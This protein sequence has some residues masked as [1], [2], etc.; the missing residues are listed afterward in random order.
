MDRPREPLP[1]RVQDTQILPAAYDDALD[2]GLAELGLALPDAARAATTACTCTG[3][4]D[5]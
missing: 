1:T 5:R 2:A 4:T 3:R